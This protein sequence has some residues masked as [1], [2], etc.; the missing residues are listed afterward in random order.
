VYFGR[1]ALRRWRYAPVLYLN[2]KNKNQ[3]ISLLVIYIGKQKN[4]LHLR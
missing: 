3:G 2:G 4:Q 1:A